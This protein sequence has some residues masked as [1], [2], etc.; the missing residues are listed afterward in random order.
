MAM[1]YFVDGYNVI[2][3][4]TLL[5]TLLRQSLEAARERLIDKVAHFCAA[6][7]VRATIVFDGRGL[8]RTERQPH[9][10]GVAGLEVLY[11]PN[12][13]SADTVI[14]RAVYQASDRRNI[15]VASND[16]GLRSLCRGMGALTMEAANF[17]DTMRQSVQE[18]RGML[19]S[20]RPRAGSS[21]RLEERIDGGALARLEAL[22]AQLD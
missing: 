22:R 9:D 15:V 2:Y 10:R 3:K 19:P 18:T 12:H 8:H 1:R 13:L 4:S 17:L 5:Q 14:E 6:A 21:G 20:A 16:A 11:A 7:D